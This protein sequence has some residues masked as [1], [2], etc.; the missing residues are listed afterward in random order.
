MTVRLIVGLD[1]RV[2]SKLIMHANELN[3]M[4]SVWQTLSLYIYK[5]GV[6]QTL[7]QLGRGKEE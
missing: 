6:S 5:F 2:A 1:L 4:Y 7:K 3:E